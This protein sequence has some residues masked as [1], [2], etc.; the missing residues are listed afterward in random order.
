MTMEVTYLCRKCGKK[1][2][3]QVEATASVGVDID[4][5]KNMPHMCSKKAPSVMGIGEPISVD[6]M[7]R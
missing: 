6:T 5:N 7:P 2:K 4:I 1:F 3:H